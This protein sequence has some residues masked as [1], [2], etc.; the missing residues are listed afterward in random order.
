[1]DKRIA[2]TERQVAQRAEDD[3]FARA[4]AAVA[5]ATAERQRSEVLLRQSEDLI[6]QTR[7]SAAPAPEQA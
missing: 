5:A 2:E 1:M 7:Q 6:E 4:S 3:M